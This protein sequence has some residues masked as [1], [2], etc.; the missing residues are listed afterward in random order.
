MSYQ[1]SIPPELAKTYEQLPPS[2]RHPIEERLDM[3][4]AAAEDAAQSPSKAGRPH[5]KELAVVSPG[6][7]R[8]FLADQWIEYRVQPE[9]H[10][11]QLVDFGS[12]SMSPL[13]HKTPFSARWHSAGQQEDGWDNE[14]GGSPPFPS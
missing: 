3:L 4:A 1:V 6:T 2:E 8:I 12:W 10:L 9:D 14:G 11:L 13:A 7:H 5:A